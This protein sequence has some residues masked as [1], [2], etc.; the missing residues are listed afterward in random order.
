LWY[1]LTVLI[2]NIFKTFAVHRLTMI[3]SKAHLS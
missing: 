2:V 1:I 3:S